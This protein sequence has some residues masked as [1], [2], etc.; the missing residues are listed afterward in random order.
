MTDLIINGTAITR[1]SRGARRYYD[2]IMANL[3]WPG[4]ISITEPWSRLTRFKELAERGRSDAI[5]WSPAHR[6]PLFA[7]NH[8]VTVLDCINIE[9][10]YCDDARLPLLRAMMGRLLAGARQ[11]V[12]ISEATRAAV[13]RNFVI[14]PAK[15]SV[16][17]GPTVLPIA[18]AA[19]A[20]VDDDDFVLM[21]TNALPHKNTAFAA[22]AMAA[23][24]ARE[25]G[26]GLR[27]VGALAEGSA[28]LCAAAGVKVE[29]FHNVDDA[30]LYGWMR[31]C[32]FL[33][34]PSLA[35]G[36]N[37]PIAEAVSLG[38]N[39]VCSDIAVHQEFF[40]SDALFFDPLSHAS[41]VA[42]LDD[43][44][45]R[46]GRWFPATAKPGPTFGDVAAQYR[47]LFERMAP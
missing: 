27:V 42:V 40:A 2:G 17:A 24:R 18:N 6:G 46:S 12:C 21:V 16:I 22:A 15:L 9:H 30:T 20:H 3:D 8:V 28:A 36:L 4:E 47:A 38:V 23:S 11:I 35:E 10:V 1:S 14:D 45:Q 29:I 25:L 19:I 39:V 44:L 43:A 37:L 26:I 5:Y 33:L 31:R 13:E 32:R 7:H 34:S 41:L